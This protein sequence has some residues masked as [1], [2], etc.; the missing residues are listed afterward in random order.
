[1]TDNPDEDLQAAVRR[2]TV[3]R[4]NALRLAEAGE[5]LFREIL[6]T[7]R[8]LIGPDGEGDH[9]ALAQRLNAALT[10]YA[11]AAPEVRRAVEAAKG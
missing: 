10:R 9:V 2:L 8:E 4:A 1:M 11:P 7:L 6:D 5:T 3:E